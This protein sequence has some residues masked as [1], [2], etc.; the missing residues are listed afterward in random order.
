MLPLKDT[1]RSYTFPLINWILIGLNAI[2]FLFEISLSPGELDQLVLRY[3]VIAERFNFSDPA[4]LLA[5]PSALITLFTHLFLHGGWFHFLSNMWILYIFG[6]NVEDR[7]G[8]GRYLAFYLL[9][10]LAAAF[11]QILFTPG[12]AIPAIGASG[13]IAGVLGA[14]LLMFPRSRVITFIPIF[15][16]PWFVDIPAVFYLGIWFISQLFSGITALGSVDA[17]GVAWWAHIGG[18]VFGMIA[19]RLFTQR[20]H[21]AFTR[22]YPDEYWPF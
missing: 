14:Y 18:F 15:L 5:D 16:L 9:S 4:S 10:G 8:S 17:G 13:A 20:R 7:M 22:T 19:Y 6:D 11:T 3:G 21:P 1:I 12:S 2:V